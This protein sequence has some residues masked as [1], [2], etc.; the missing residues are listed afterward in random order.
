MEVVLSVLKGF[1]YTEKTGFLFPLILPKIHHSLTAYPQN[2]L[3]SVIL[4]LHRC[5]N[6][7][8]AII[9]AN[10][11]LTKRWGIW[12]K[13]IGEACIRVSRSLRILAFLGYSI[14]YLQI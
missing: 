5:N 11:S 14:L 3:F 13:K 7:Y 4:V 1:Y 6:G 12:Y 8:Q 9:I 10:L 2:N